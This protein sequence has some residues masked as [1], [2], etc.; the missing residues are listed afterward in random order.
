MLHTEA[1]ETVEFHRPRNPKEPGTEA[2]QSLPRPQILPRV[3][4]NLVER[5][6]QEEIKK[7]RWNSLF[8]S[9]LLRETL[10]ITP[11]LL[12]KGIR[13]ERKDSTNSKKMWDNINLI[14]NRKR[15][16]SIIDNVQVN[17][18]NLHQPASIS[19][20]I[21]KDFYSVPTELATSLPKADRHFASFMKGKNVIYALLR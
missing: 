18:K 2:G 8:F 11:T 13:V 5:T 9:R 1:G 19:N 6:R 10:H 14:I 15:P 20:A 21:N 12:F 7:T 17:G 3:L 4:R 16:S